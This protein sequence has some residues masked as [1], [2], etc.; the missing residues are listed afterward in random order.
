MKLILS[1]FSLSVLLFGLG[2]SLNL[3][4][5]KTSI[6][7]KAAGDVI[8]PPPQIIGDGIV[9][10]GQKGPFGNRPFFNTDDGYL[11]IV[12][13]GDKF[14]ST[15]TAKFDS[16]VEAYKAELLKTNPF[17]YWKDHIRFQKILN[18]SSQTC[19]RHPDVYRCIV[20]YQY[21]S[22]SWNYNSLYKQ[23]EDAGMNWDVVAVIYNDPEYGGCADSHIAAISNEYA[24]QASYNQAA[25]VFV[26]ELGHAAFSLG[27]EY[28]LTY[29]TNTKS[30]IT[31]PENCFAGMPP[32]PAWELF[33]PTNSYQRLAGCS[34]PNWYRSSESSIMRDLSFVYFNGP[35]VEKINSIFELFA[36]SHVWTPTNTAIQWVYPTNLSSFSLGVRELQ[37][38]LS[39]PEKVQNLEMYI[40]DVFVKTIFQS[41]KFPNQLSIP[42]WDFPISSGTHTFEFRALDLYNNLVGTSEKQTFNIL[43]S[44]TPRCVSS[45]ISAPTVYPDEVFTVTTTVQY[46]ILPFERL[47][48]LDQE[49]NLAPALIGPA[50]FGNYQIRT[51]TSAAP[52]ESYI[53]KTDGNPS[54]TDMT[55]FTWQMKA[56]YLN[57]TDFNF[58][59]QK[60]KNITFQASPKF[61]GDPIIDKQ[62]CQVSLNV[63]PRPTP[64]LT[65]TPIPTNTPVPTIVPTATTAPVRI[66]RISDLLYG[67][68]EYGKPS[69]LYD[70]NND[71][72]VN[73]LDFAAMAK[74][75]SL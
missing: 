36:P 8:P 18:T 73:F 72:V 59:G 2:I 68:M 20:C 12:F 29:E 52:N 64:T 1:L 45:N 4:K 6:A 9:M 42:T 35:S 67:V 47:R 44:Q 48:I 31:P 26:H 11:D 24:D 69:E 3:A 50:A 55:T 17:S 71:G 14:G 22:G 37:F 49:N 30:Q 57:G 54:L 63:V 34:Y 27:D 39:N 61:Y 56:E 13:F 5:Q 40:D 7:T 62:N 65:P 41:Y 43:A 51:D 25:R 19:Q 75:V 70:I 15:E 60:L 28:L 21:D 16:N 33:T 23:L 58:N 74:N 66:Y 53:Y 46:P 32:N 38:Q 10:P